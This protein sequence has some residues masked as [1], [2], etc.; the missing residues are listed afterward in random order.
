MKNNELLQN[1]LNE[2]LKDLATE[3]HN[4]EQLQK[5]LDAQTTTWGELV[6]VVK[7]IPSETS[8]ALDGNDSTLAKLLSS[9]NTTQEK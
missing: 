9:E 3:K 1:T 8:K 6:E 5:N 7:Q 4:A 2:R